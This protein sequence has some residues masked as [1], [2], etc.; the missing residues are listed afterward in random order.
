MINF[1]ASSAFRLLKIRMI[2]GMVSLTLAMMASGPLAEMG[3]V[4]S[5]IDIIETKSMVTPIQQM[6]TD[7]TM[8]GA[9]TAILAHLVTV[10]VVIRVVFIPDAPST[11][12]V[13]SFT[14]PI[15]GFAAPIFPH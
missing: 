7:S 3:S 5:S 10:G 13:Q 4:T 2:T 14:P 11:Q 9:G 15:E 8:I 12:Q 1:I 6:T